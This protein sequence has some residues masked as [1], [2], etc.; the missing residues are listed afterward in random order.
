MVAEMDELKFYFS[1]FLRRLPW[2]VVLAT[3]ITA[4]AV[5]VAISLPPAYVS[6]MRLV[7]ESPQIPD[8]MAADIGSNG[9]GGSRSGV[10]SWR[11]KPGA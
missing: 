6:Q 7:V 1:I 11:Q 4:V 10:S 5:S 8:E 9:H 3:V 2:F